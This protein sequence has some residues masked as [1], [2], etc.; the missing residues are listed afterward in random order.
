MIFLFPNG[1]LGNQFLL[2][3]AVVAMSR[4]NEHVFAINYHSAVNFFGPSPFIHFIGS[5]A[6]YSFY[7]RLITRFIYFVYSRRVFFSRLVSFLEESEL[8]AV[9][10][11]LTSP[12]PP[13]FTI[14]YDCYLQNECFF[15]STLPPSLF[16]SS[17]LSSR[18][19]N[20]F[21]VRN[22]QHDHKIFLHI[23]RGDYLT[24]SPSPKIVSCVPPDSYYL[25]SLRYLL[26]LYPESVV[27]VSSDD[28]AYVQQLFLEF[29]SIFF[30]NE[31]PLF[32][33]AIMSQCHSGILSPSS[34]SF[35]AAYLSFSF[36]FSV[37]SSPIYIAPKYWIGFSILGWYPKFFYARFIKYIL[38]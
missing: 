24:W 33:L 14:I 29:N 22:I 13:L 9:S 18:V 17:S 15:E 1:Q 6:R 8:G 26:T 23:R 35:A 4:P 7:K 10:S 37:S 34:F 32:A 30:V 12:F 5:G 36:S 20:W 31:D 2:L 27:I 11:S 21:S 25:D 38:I 28:Y 3:F 19:S 16:I